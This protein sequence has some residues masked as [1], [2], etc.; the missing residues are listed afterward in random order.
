MPTKPRVERFGVEVFHAGDVVG[1]ESI[2]VAD[3]RVHDRGYLLAVFVGMIQTKG[4]TKF[5]DRDPAK[6]HGIGFERPAVGIPG[7][8]RI[9]N[10]VGLFE[11]VSP[12]VEQSDRKGAG[13]EFIA[14]DI[15]GKKSRVLVVG[16]IGN[17]R[18]KEDASQGQMSEIWI[19]DIER[20]LSGL[21][22]GGRAVS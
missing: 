5:M 6:I 15:G 8:G 17:D 12:K 14:K 11:N 22:E 4:V 16:S 3:L 10:G 7:V 9:E 13:S 20:V 18:R 19:P 21:I 1:L 2:D